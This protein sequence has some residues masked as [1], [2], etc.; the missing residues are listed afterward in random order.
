MPGW[1][2]A[3]NGADYVTRNAQSNPYF[4]LDSDPM[5]TD[6]IMLLRTKRHWSEA[7]PPTQGGL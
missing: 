2:A 1:A 6:A 4:G 5:R 3:E 7:G